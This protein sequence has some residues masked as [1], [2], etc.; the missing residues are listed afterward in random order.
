M[1]AALGDRDILG[2][3]LVPPALPAWRRALGHK[4]IDSW[5][6]WRVMLIAAM[7]EPLTTDELEVF[8]QFTGGRDAPTKPISEGAFVI[9]RRGG[10]DRA[11]SVLAAYLATRE[12]P[13]LVA[14]E[15][16]QLLV[17]SVHDAAATIQLSYIHAALQ[18]SPV[19]RKLIEKKTDDT[20]RL[21]NG[22]D[23]VVRAASFRRVRGQTAVGIISSENA[24]WLNE[25]QSANPDRE[26]LRALRPSLLTTGGPLIQISSP[27][28]RR[29][30]LYDT[31]RRYFGKSGPIMVVQGATTDFNP[32]AN[33]GEIARAYEEDAEAARAE[34]GGEFRDDLIDFISREAVMRCI[35]KGV[36]EI[37]PGRSDQYHA[38]VDP[39]GG[40]SDSMTMAISHLEDDRVIVDMVREATPPFSP[41]AVVQE[42]ASILRK[43]R[44]TRVTGDNYGAEWVKESFRNA[45]ISYDRSELPASALYL[46]LLPAI[47]TKSVLLLD[48]AK[49]L[50]Q[51]CAL[52]RRVG[53]SGRDSVGHHPNTHD[54]LANAIAGATYLAGVGSSRRGTVSTG[55]WQG[56]AVRW[57]S[58]ERES[59]LSASHNGCIPHPS[60]VEQKYGSFPVNT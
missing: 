47:N 57:T 1:R 12:Y 3:V 23:V 15:R 36:G 14:G 16:G 60:R 55:T 29:G 31:H 25:S 17:L 46:E 22:V 37:G 56:G 44:I 40:S 50:N 27:Y 7:G 41:E 34:Y 26:I 21:S 38:F 10:K 28:A 49:A 11:A 5:A 33:A 53:R 45:G 51:I 6:N 52:E 59:A 48:H 4:P 54:D 9:G 43:Y 32:T 58:R 20:I 19:L 18:G 24:F 42:F 2:N 35:N 30:A 8:K 13:M 39:S